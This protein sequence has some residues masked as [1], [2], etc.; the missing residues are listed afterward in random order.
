MSNNYYSLSHVIAIFDT[1]VK[2]MFS[3]PFASPSWDSE[4]TFSSC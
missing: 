4:Q 1:V 3:A 2:D